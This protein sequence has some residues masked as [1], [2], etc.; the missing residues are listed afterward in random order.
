MDASVAPEACARVGNIRGDMQNEF[1]QGGVGELDK[2]SYLFFREFARCE[3]SLKAAGLRE[4]QRKD[5]TADWGG[6][7]ACG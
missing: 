1:E 7:C 3:Y 4:S 5:P 6:I 2:L